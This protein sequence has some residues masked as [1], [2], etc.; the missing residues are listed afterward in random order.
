[1]P[2]SKLK[3]SK[4]GEVRGASEMTDEQNLQHTSVKNIPL[5]AGRDPHIPRGNEQSTL[6]RNL[7]KKKIRIT[8]V[9]MKRIPASL[10]SKET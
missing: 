9:H 4:T 8:N 1:M 2:R 5:L 3:S 6:A 10:G 7:Q